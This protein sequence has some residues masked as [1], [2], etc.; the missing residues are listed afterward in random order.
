VHYDAS[1]LAKIERVE[2]AASR[3]LA[4]SCDAATA[5]WFAASTAHAIVAGWRPA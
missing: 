5:G 3:D 2:R 1:L 4:A